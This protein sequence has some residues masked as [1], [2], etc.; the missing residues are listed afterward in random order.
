MAY[1]D[2][3]YK[4]LESSQTVFMRT[5]RKS[6][7]E[8]LDKFLIG[9]AKQ[10]TKDCVKRIVEES[11]DSLIYMEMQSLKDAF[12][13]LDNLDEKLEV[14]K[15]LTEMIDG[16]MDERAKTALLLY[17][18]AKTGDPLDDNFARCRKITAAGLIAAAYLGLNHYEVS[19]QAEQ[20]NKTNK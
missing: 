17:E 11:A 19:N 20:F 5:F 13:E 1:K 15:S 4:H 12:T 8:R 14:V 9:Q 7:D 16:I 10:S 2:R 3:W 6:L 18:R